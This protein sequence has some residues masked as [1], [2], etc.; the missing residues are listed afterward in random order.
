MAPVS[1]HTSSNFES[2]AGIVGL[3][4]VAD[5]EEIFRAS[6]LRFASLIEYATQGDQQARHEL[7]RLRLAYLNWAYAGGENTGAELSQYR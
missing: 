7:L 2:L 6:Q 5:P 3:P 4:A 1:V